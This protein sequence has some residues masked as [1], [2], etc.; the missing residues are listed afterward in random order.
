MKKFKIAVLTTSF[1][2][3]ASI[4]GSVAFNKAD[5]SPENFDA[6]GSY[7]KIGKDKKKEDLLKYKEN[8]EFKINKLAAEVN[9]N[10]E[11]LTI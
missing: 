2:L 8:N 1:A 7:E 3:T 11:I 5:A 9:E 6:I 10:D 4:L